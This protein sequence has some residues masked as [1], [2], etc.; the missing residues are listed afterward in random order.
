[1]STPVACLGVNGLSQA[2]ISEITEYRTDCRAGYE[3]PDH[4]FAAEA[5]DDLLADAAAYQQSL[6]ALT[7]QLAA[8]EARAAAAEGKLE[9]LK[10][11]L[12]DQEVQALALVREVQSLRNANFKLE[13]EASQKDKRHA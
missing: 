12:A 10:Q 1:M 9:G 5:I 7:S 3:I 11:E 13:H 2:R 4:G 6:A 8:A